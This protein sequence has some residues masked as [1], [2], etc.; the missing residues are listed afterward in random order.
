MGITE[1]FGE[2]KVLRRPGFEYMGDLYAG[3]HPKGKITDKL[4]PSI[5]FHDPSQ[6]LTRSIRLQNSIKIKE[7]DLVENDKQ[8]PRS[9]MTKINDK[10][11]DDIKDRM[12]VS[13]LIPDDKIAQVLDD[14]DDCVICLFIPY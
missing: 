8:F 1:N 11:T 5:P 12:Q 2:S 13:N 4:I 7:S 6:S 3:L 9:R 10:L 14:D